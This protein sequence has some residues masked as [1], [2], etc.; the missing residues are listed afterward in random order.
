M[1]VRT[2]WTLLGVLIVGSIAVG[3]STQ[4]SQA[5]D[6]DWH[7]QPWLLGAAIAG[8]IAIEL[9]HASIWR[10][11]LRLMGQRIEPRRSRSIWFTS[12]LA[13]YVPTGALM[14]VVRMRLA[15]AAGVRKRV[16]LA[17]VLY[18][19]ALTTVGSLVV[20]A[21]F[22]L[23]LPALEE[24][25]ARFAV[26][27]LPV[28]AAIG[29]HP[30]VFG[31]VSARVLARLGREPVPATLRPAGMFAC[32]A[33][34]A[35]TFVVG[36]LITWAVVASLHPVD[37]GDLPAVITAFG[38]GYTVSVLAF[39]LPGGLGA[40][41]A[42]LAAALAV[43]VPA[44]VAVAAAVALRLIQIGVELLLAAATRVIAARSEAGAGPPASAQ[45]VGDFAEV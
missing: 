3:V 16:S 27:A 18:E 44:A 19:V 22:F 26:L 21:Y 9:A 25:S 34:Y 24:H 28:A 36:G 7:F 20:G 39:M 23:Q 1:L 15:E 30:A 11:I 8:M 40:R 17:S 13:R 4:L 38:V 29:L 6:Y 45:A 43:A 12:I 33:L 42:A 14:A 10:L 2:A 35:L 31:R 37:S 5:A 32:V 41:E